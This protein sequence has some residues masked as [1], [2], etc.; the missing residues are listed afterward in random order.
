MTNIYNTISLVSINLIEE[1][2]YFSIHIIYLNLYRNI[3]HVLIR[4]RTDCN[5]E[6]IFETNEC[7]KKDLWSLVS[8]KARQA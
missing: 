6:D 3:K 1:Y 5:L 2:T 4:R 8:V 7:V